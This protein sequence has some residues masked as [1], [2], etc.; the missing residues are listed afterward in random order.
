MQVTSIDNTRISVEFTHKQTNEHKHE[1]EGRGRNLN[2]LS[3]QIKINSCNF[4]CVLVK[5]TL[6]KTAT[7]LS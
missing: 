6:D 7:E 1:G 3:N 5:S 4:L 2:L